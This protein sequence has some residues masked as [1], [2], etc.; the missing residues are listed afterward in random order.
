MNIGM[1][2]YSQFGHTFSVAKRLQDALSEAGHTVTL[3]RIKPVGLTKPGLTD[4]PLRAEPQIEG[5]D[6]LVFGTPVWGGTPASPMASYLAQLVSLEGIPV[7]CLVTGF[8]PAD[9]GRNQTLAQLKETCEA[10]GATVRAVGSVGWWSFRRRRQIVEVV[11][12]L[13]GLF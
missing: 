10:K 13:S 1:I 9:W 4:V 2:V 5:Y 12:R 11:E 3:E 8:F 6:A 7:V